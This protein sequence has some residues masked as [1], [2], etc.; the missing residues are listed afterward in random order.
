LADR[1]PTNLL[2]LADL[3]N[4]LKKFFLLALILLHG[5]PSIQWRVFV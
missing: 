5:R 1:F 2:A 3:Q 4:G